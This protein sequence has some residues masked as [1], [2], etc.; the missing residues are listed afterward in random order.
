L[1]TVTTDPPGASIR[2]AGRI[3]CDPSPCNFSVDRD[4]LVRVEAVKPGYRLAR[5]ELKAERD[6]TAVQLVLHPR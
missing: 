1:V 5:T 3:E 6:P 4:A 2:V